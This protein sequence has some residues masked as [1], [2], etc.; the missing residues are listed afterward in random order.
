MHASNTNIC[1]SYISVLT[2][3]VMFDFPFSSNSSFDRM[4]STFLRTA[5][6][7]IR[8][9]PCLAIINRNLPIDIL[10]SVS[11]ATSLAPCHVTI[12]IPINDIYYST[13]PPFRLFAY[14]VAYYRAYPES[15]DTVLRFAYLV[16]FVFQNLG[17]V[18]SRISSL[19]SSVPSCIVH[20]HFLNGLSRWIGRWR[21]QFHRLLSASC[22]KQQV[23][24]YVRQYIQLLRTR[25]ITTV[26]FHPTGRVFR[27]SLTE[28]F[29]KGE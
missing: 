12:S 9:L 18:P 20:L 7:T 22:L 26:I 10:Q 23:C 21:W 11:F 8:F 4:P 24:I 17:L 5:V 2:S 28:T 13:L 16:P 29:L 3:H 27:R 19:R 1:T 25:E 14:Y 15:S 6:F